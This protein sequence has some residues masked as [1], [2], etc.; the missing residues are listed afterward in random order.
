MSIL[1]MP[2]PVPLPLPVPMPL[3]LPLPLPHG[4]EPVPWH[5]VDNAVG[6]ATGIVGVVSHCVPCVALLLLLPCAGGS[7]PSL[8]P[9]AEG[10]TQF[11]LWCIMKSPLLIGTFLHNIS[12][13]TLAT[14]TNKVSP[15][16]AVAVSRHCTLHTGP[17][18][19][20]WHCTQPV[21]LSI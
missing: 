11:A 20:T 15:I 10:R 16:T 14:V 3:P 7:P 8:F 6:V 17:P 12:G 13:A 21:D 2:V 4:V 18:M 19:L 1:M 5:A 9:D